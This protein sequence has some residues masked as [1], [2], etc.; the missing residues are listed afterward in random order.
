M[1]KP[2]IKLGLG[3]VQWGTRYGISN[4]RGQTPANEVGEMLAIAQSAGIS[5]LDTAAQYGTAEATLGEH[6]LA[7]TFRVVTKTPHFGARVIKP[8]HQRQLL[9]CFDESLLRLNAHSV[10]GLLIHNAPDL[11]MPGGTLLIESLERLKAEGRVEKVGVSVYSS[12]QI[13]ALLNFF[14]P[15]VIQ[16]PLNV[17]DQR[18]IKSGDI[19]R[20]KDLDIEVHVRS[21]FLQGLLLMPPEE[22]PVNLLPY[23][24]PLENWRELVRELGVTPRQAALA[25]V[26]DNKEVDQLIIGVETAV[27]L[28]EC[29]ADYCADVSFSGYDFDIQDVTL[30]NPASWAN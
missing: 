15:D 13:R 24:K 22:L 12:E 7:T 5:L 3:T 23:R 2:S 28:Q 21:V 16:L 8:Y 10:Y 30:L 25:F 29:L 4:R 14:K 27:Q 19:S 26:R 18:L 20:L 6:G 9:K 17:F 11:I 1:I